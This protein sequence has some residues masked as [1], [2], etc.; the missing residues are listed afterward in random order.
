MEVQNLSASIPKDLHEIKTT[1]FMGIT[2]RQLITFLIAGLVGVP[3]YLL[4]YMVLKV[5]FQIAVCIMIVI[6]APIFFIG[7]YN[8]N[9][10]S[11]EKLL[12]YIYLCEFKRPKKR[13]YD[14][15]PKGIKKR[16]GIKNND[17]QD[18]KSIP[19]N[20]KNR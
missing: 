10:L 13:P 20:S 1:V 7:L 17:R 3:L 19:K 15:R 16:E 5:N 11:A 18:S 12:Y 9:G 4:L 2:K 14:I 6:C 8:H